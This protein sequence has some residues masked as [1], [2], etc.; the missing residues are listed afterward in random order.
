MYDLIIIGG[1][2]AGLTAGIY[3]VRAGLKTLIL[4]KLAAG[5]QMALS[6]EIENYPGFE[7]ITGAELAEKMRAHAVVLGAEFRSGSVKALHNENG[8]WNVDAGRKNYEA[9]AIIAATGGVRR[10]LEVPG[11]EELA[12]MGVSYC[13][14]CDGGF[15]KDKTVAVVGGGNTA[16]EDAVY[17]SG[18]CRKVYLI[19]RREGFRAEKRLVEQLDARENVEKVLNTVVEAIE[20]SG[21]VERLKIKNKVT[22]ESSELP[23]DGVF[24][25][26]GVIPE[27]EWLKGILSLDQNGY[28]IAGEDCK[29]EVEGLF[30]AG[31]LRKK[32]IY[33]II[34]AA[35]DGATAATAA[36]QFIQGA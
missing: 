9:K 23:V 14:T 5:G 15:F 8:I 25:A 26:A 27:T 22:G 17:L 31:D 18:I 34:T 36:I 28:V 33:Q 32:P 11:E 4:E 7:K 21:A 6:Y 16:F 19:H 10:K 12:G 24:A 20:G 1:G 30:V 29:T 13:A 35:A 2:P 3:A